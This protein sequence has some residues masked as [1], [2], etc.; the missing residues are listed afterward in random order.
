M[1]NRNII[2]LLT[3]VLLSPLSASYLFAMKV[4]SSSPSLYHAANQNSRFRRTM[5][6]AHAI[7]PIKDGFS[8]SLCDGH[9]GDKTALKVADQKTGLHTLIDE[10]LKEGKSPAKAYE[11]AFPEY[12]EK[13]CTEAHNGCTVITAYLHAL[14]KD[15][16]TAL[17]AVLGD[18]RALI[19]RDGKVVFS[20][21]E[22]EHK[23]SG[24]IENKRIIDAGGFVTANRVDGI[25]AVARALGDA[26]FKTD[27]KKPHVS[28]HPTILTRDLEEN[29]I[30]A[31]YC[32]GVHDVLSDD[33]AAEIIAAAYTSHENP[34][35]KL[36]D[37]AL[38]SGS[39]DNI[40]AITL[41][42]D[43]SVIAQLVS[44]SYK[45]DLLHPTSF[46]EKPVISAT[47]A[48]PPAAIT[49]VV[50]APDTEVTYEA[51]VAPRRTIF[52][53]LKAWLTSL[54]PGSAYSASE[55]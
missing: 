31:L 53:S 38:A 9:G 46:T 50:E 29:D 37:T 25:L 26:S 1:K 2:G 39:T 16:L 40:S 55:F 12:D 14:D 27:R 3:I 13:Y 30:L 6:D 10:K 51:P 28:P 45:E 43:A 8:L 49:P 7:I 19:I 42:I 47:T 36:V 35:Q 52:S 33:K 20:T 22:H 17:I 15:T 5:E 48:T 18:S 21:R 34:A 24:E 4:D 44:G 32:D 11:E 23:P 54:I 41:K